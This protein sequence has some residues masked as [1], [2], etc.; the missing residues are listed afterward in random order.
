MSMRKRTILLIAVVSLSTAGLLQ[1]Q[2]GN[3][4]VELEVEYTS[5]YIW[6]G[7]ELMAGKATILPKISVDWFGTGFSTTVQA[8]YAGSGASKGGAST[9]NRTEYQYIMAYD[10]SFFE[11]E[12]H[13]VD[14]GINFIYRDFIDNPSRGE[15]GSTDVGDTQEIGAS[16][17]LPNICSIDVVPSYYLGKI[18]PSQN[19][20]V[21]T[22]KYGGW[23]HIFR[24]DYE[25]I[26]PGFLPE[27]PEQT[28]N[29]MVDVVYNDGYGSASVKHDWSHAT[30]GAVMPIPIGEVDVKPG[31]YYQV[32]FEE[33]LN[34]DKKN[35]LYGGLTV[36]YGF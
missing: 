2:E 21:L 4:G 10:R 11:G 34:S 9:V 15:S 30:L 17:A 12:V 3:L 36:S 28:L 27:T 18:W 22:G 8:A 29:L 6:H 33:S 7:F 1:A 23:I 25:L 35:I 14:L 24:L 16:I 19:N 31:I 5:K 13:T 32:T 26:V 20:S